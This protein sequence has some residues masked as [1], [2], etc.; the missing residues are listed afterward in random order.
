[1]TPEELDSYRSS[2]L[3]NLGEHLIGQLEEDIRKKFAAWN[4]Y[5]N[6]AKNAGGVKSDSSHPHLPV[7]MQVVTMKQADGPV[8]DEVSLD[9]LPTDG[10]VPMKVEVSRP[11]FIE[12]KDARLPEDDAPAE[13][14]PPEH[15]AGL[16]QAILSEHK[17]SV[18]FLHIAESWVWRGP[19]DEYVP[20]E[21]DPD[22]G[23]REEALVVTF[24][25]MTGGVMTGVMPIGETNGLRY[26]KP[27]E[28]GTPFNRNHPSLN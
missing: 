17:N 3:H 10:G 16:M 2:M 27:L 5:V 7:E 9:D 11:Y 24:Q 25:M 8:F 4:Q 15:M 19:L 26:L 28:F 23:P 1:M 14:T 22:A 13:Y 18:G 12:F 6:E 21:T 20:Y